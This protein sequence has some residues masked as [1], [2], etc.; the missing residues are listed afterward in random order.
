M[1]AARIVFIFGLVGGRKPAEREREFTLGV[2]VSL[3]RIVFHSLKFLPRIGR[4]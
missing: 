2:F 3:R 4:G 1:H